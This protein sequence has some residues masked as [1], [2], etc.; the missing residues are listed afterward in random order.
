M[1]S[2]VGVDVGGTTTRAV[3]FDAAHVPSSSRSA[4]TPRG[5]D[6]VVELVATLVEELAAGAPAPPEAV[7]VG[8]P[9]RIDVARGM[10]STAVNLGITEPVAMAERLRA[11]LA[12]PVH[13]ENDVNSAAL[14]TYAHFGLAPPASL[15][16]V[17]VGTGIAAGFVLGGRLLRGAT[18]GAGEIGHIPMRPDGPPCPCG[19]VGCAEAVGSGRAVAA[20]ASPEDVFSA[21]AWAVQ[22]C[23]MTLD[24][25]VVV[26]GGG[27]TSTEEPFLLGL[28]E[29]LAKSEATSPMLAATGLARRVRLAPLDVPLGSLGA[30]LA[31][32]DRG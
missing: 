9:G 30:V 27:M 16:Y 17:N 24:V 19:Q 2:T 11:R 31:A 12:V 22:L 28:H 15:A 18:G 8:I 20:D 7:A 1:A 29:A 4:P 26:V 10:V 25:D 6:A 23:V 14:G 3:V 5:G 21:V 13:I 32:R